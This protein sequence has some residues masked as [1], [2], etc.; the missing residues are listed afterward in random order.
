MTTLETAI[1]NFAPYLGHHR[2]FDD[3]RAPRPHHLAPAEPVD[4]EYLTS[5]TCTRQP[6][7]A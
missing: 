4:L 2:T 3:T 6:T 1:N 7:P 5:G